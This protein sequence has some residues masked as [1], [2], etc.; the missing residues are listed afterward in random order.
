M[1]YGK[2]YPYLKAF[3]DASIEAAPNW[4]KAPGRFVS[5]LS[6]QLKSQ[7]QEENKQ[8]EKEIESLSEDQLRQIQGTGHLYHHKRIGDH[9]EAGAQSIEGGPR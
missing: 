7:R 2:A 4:A 8:F 9:R 5:S 3:L 1:E 6:E